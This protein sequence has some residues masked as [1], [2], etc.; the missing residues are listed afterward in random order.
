MPQA[1]PA[2]SG[3]PA[4]FTAPRMR[5][6]SL[7][8]PRLSIGIVLVALSV[9]LGAWALDTGRTLET[10]Y[11]PARTIQAGEE[12]T[13]NDLQPID[14]ELGQQLSSYLTPENLTPGSVALEPLR[15]GQLIPIV[16]TGSP[17][18]VT[19][20]IIAVPITGQLPAQVNAGSIVDLWFAPA[21]DNTGE[22]ED[23]TS[24]ATG[25]TVAQIP[26]EGGA[27][28]VGTNSYLHV[29]VPEDNI[30]DVLAAT[31]TKG[32]LTALPVPHTTPQAPSGSTEDTTTTGTDTEGDNS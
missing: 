32:A 30:A 12:I 14:V 3:T 22:T 8:D 31:Q 18:D 5:Q 9:W 13:A 26:E 25:L 11:I 21:Q 16:A 10:A 2:V 27:F 1:A 20:R 24:V 29:V 15:Q 6:P 7:K 19:S 28:G 23:P 17:D 4:A